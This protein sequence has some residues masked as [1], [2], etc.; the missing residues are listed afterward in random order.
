M[1]SPNSLHVRPALD[2][3][4]KKGENMQK[5]KPNEIETHPSF[6]EL[7]PIREEL[8]KKIET[9][10]KEGTYDLSQPVILATWDGQKEPVCIDG[11][12]R[13]KA[14]INAGID[15]LPVWTHKFDTE[16]EAIKK[17]VKLQQNRRNLSDADITVCVAMLDSKRL[18]GGDRK[19]EKAK[20][21][22]SIDAIENAPSKS[23]AETAELL[24]ISTTKV[25]RTRN[26][27]EHG[28]QETIDEVKQGKKSINKANTEIRE[29]RKKKSSDDKPKKQKS[30]PSD[31]Q[32][33]DT[34][35]PMVPIPREYR[36]R[37]KE[38]GGVIEDH[39][40]CAIKHYLELMTRQEEEGSS[41]K[42]DQVV[43]EEY[44]D[45]GDYDD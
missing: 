45:D 19:S 24:G 2:A 4:R 35:D 36:G 44:F 28:D 3:G 1:R 22:A 29:K 23:A 39:V 26:L 6:E 20:S 42:V 32:H 33:D 43:D 16:E 14:A 38:L 12:T 37:L 41:E 15:E 5:M 11:H 34:A 30:N 13:L 17:A 18:R 27:L 9:D 40:A 8:L 31:E 7:F 10:M 21:K 25:E